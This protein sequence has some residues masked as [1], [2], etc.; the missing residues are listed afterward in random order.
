MSAFVPR[1]INGWAGCG[2]PT[3]VPPNPH[4]LASVL[5]FSKL[6]VLAGLC[7]E[8]ALPLPF[9]AALFESKVDG[10]LRVGRWLFA[11]MAPNAE[12][13]LNTAQDKWA[14]MLLGVPPWKPAHHASWELGWQLSCFARAVLDVAFRRARI[15]S[16]PRQDWYRQM[17]CEAS[18]SPAS[19]AARS[20]KLLQDW[21][22][23]D[24]SEGNMSLG[25]RAYKK[26][27]KRRP[28]RRLP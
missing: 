24:F 1:S 21:G 28:E 7:I 2:L 25:V 23:R 12:S 20:S 4:M 17:F 22:I 16:W 10:T 15:Q 18:S 6:C 27:C 19:W 5:L 13:E 3:V 14:R 9:A 11:V 8:A 26:L